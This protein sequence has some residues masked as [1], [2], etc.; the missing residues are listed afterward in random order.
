VWVVIL[1]EALVKLE[2]PYAIAGGGGGK[3][4]SPTPLVFIL[5]PFN[6]VLPF[7]AVCHTEVSVLV[8]V[9]RTFS[10]YLWKKDQHGT[11]L[12]GSARYG[13]RRISTVH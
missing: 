7:F 1:K 4:G 9:V 8:Q 6:S 12:E 3:D 5:P 11:T 2:G 10:I 13:I